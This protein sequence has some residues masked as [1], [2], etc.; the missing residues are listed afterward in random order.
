M[1]PVFRDTAPQELIH[2]RAAHIEMQSP[3]HL[4]KKSGGRFAKPG[5]RDPPHLFADFVLSRPG[6]RTDRG[7]KA[8]RI[9]LELRRQLSN[10]LRRDSGDCPSPAGVNRS[11]NASFRFDQQH[12]RTIGGKL[13]D[14]QIRF[15]TDETVNEAKR[16]VPAVA[17]TT[18]VV[19]RHAKHMRT[20]NLIR[21]DKTIEREA[22]P[23]ADAATAFDGGVGI[24]TD[25]R[26]H[27][28]GPGCDDVMK[29]GYVEERRELK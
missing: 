29:T 14:G 6:A 25:V 9:D 4:R 12:E 10:Q 7:D 16:R 17:T 2:I 28:P 15:V 5:D 13:H 18:G 23:F 21:R 3:R 27:V 24:G 8:S 1:N 20:V 19:R 22:G 26:R 11:E